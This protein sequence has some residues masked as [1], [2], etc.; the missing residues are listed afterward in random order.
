MFFSVILPPTTILCIDSIVD[1]SDVPSS[2]TEDE[3][4]SKKACIYMDEHDDGVIS[5]QLKNSVGQ[6]FT[7]MALQSVWSV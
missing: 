2:Y 1:A 3:T 5:S 4:P 7:P 6:T